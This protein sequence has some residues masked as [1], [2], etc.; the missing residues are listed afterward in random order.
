MR[1]TVCVRNVVQ[2]KAAHDE[3][4]APVGVRK[5]AHIAGVELAAIGD[6]FAG[7]LIRRSRDQRSEVLRHAVVWRKSSLGTD[8]AAGSRFVERVLTVVQTLRLQRRNVLDYMTAACE[9]SLRGDRA[10]SLIAAT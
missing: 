1:A 10:P 3:I 5:L 6:T 2:R 4:E 9:A 8:R 7:F